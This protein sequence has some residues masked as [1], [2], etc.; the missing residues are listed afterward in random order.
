M[1]SNKSFCSNQ[2]YLNKKNTIYH[3][4]CLI[5]IKRRFLKV[6]NHKPKVNN[7]SVSKVKNHS[8]SKVKNHSVSISFE[9]NS[10]A[11]N[12]IG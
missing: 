7:H 2:Q 10:K 9:A 5:K 8:V 1:K 11:P 6:L 4:N 12:S 3:G